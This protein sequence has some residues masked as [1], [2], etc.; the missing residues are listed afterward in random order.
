MTLILSIH[1]TRDCEDVKDDVI[2]FHSFSYRPDTVDVETTFCGKTNYGYKTSLPRERCP[3]YARTLIRSL[4][5]DNEPFHS[6]QLNSSLFPAVIFKIEDLESDNTLNTIEDML[7]ITF[8]T[9]VTNK[10]K[11]ED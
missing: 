7:H 8:S 6:V 2:R 5:K 3:F 11:E 4:I 10:S 1:V 9:I